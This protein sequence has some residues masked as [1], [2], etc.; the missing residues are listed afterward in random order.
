MEVDQRRLS[1]RQHEFFIAAGRVFDPVDL[2]HKFG[3]L[4]GHVTTVV[5]QHVRGQDELIS[6]G[7]V[8]LNKEIEDRPFQAGT[9]APVN[10][11]AASRQLGTPLIIDQAQ[12]L[13]KLDVIFRREIEPWLFPEGPEHPVL[14]LAARGKVLVGQIRQREQEGL[15]LVFQLDQSP[16]PFFDPG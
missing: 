7:D 16:I 2:I 3:E 6:V 14:L 4:A 15:L 5:S 12:A 11:A 1:G 10:P 9:P 13:A 8:L